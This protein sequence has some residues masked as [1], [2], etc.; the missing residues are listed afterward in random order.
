MSLEAIKEVVETALRGHVAPSV[1]KEVRVSQE[2]DFDGDPI[3]SLQV[4]ID[5]NGPDLKAEKVFFATGVVRAA[6]AT[7]GDDRFPLLSFPSSDEVAEVA[8]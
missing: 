2:T 1:L 6:L 7:I 4:V 5:S 8:A 3:L